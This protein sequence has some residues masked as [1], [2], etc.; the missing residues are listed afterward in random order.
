MRFMR[1]FLGFIRFL[2]G[3]FGMER[4]IWVNGI[5]MIFGIL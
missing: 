1:F 3:I 5:L 2:L 4:F